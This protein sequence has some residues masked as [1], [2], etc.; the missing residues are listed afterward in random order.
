ME[1]HMMRRFAIAACLLGMAWVW[2]VQ[3][4]PSGARGGAGRGMRGGPMMAVQT[5]WMLLCFQLKL[6]TETLEALRPVFQ[7][8]WDDRREL[9]EDMQSGELTREELMAE[10]AAMR[11]DM[12]AAY[13]SELTDEQRAALEQARSQTRPPGGRGRR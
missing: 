11:Q 6:P 8:A 4:Q 1:V 9:F 3:A 13:Q 5:D 12:D 2:G 7:Q 10:M